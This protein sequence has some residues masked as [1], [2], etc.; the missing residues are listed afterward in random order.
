V[1]L[2]DKRVP[3]IITIASGKG[4]V[5]KTNISV[6][7]ALCLSAEERKVCLLDA[8]IGLA[9]VDI[10]L[11]LSPEHSLLDFLEDRCPLEDTIIKGPGS[12][13]IISGGSGLE[14][15]PYLGTKETSRLKQIFQRI[16][17][18]DALVIDA[19]AGIS[20]QVLRFLDVAGIPILVIV[21]EPTSLTD[22]YS[23][24]KIYNQ[25]GSR[26]PVFVLVN[27]VKSPIHGAKVFSKFSEVVKR[28]LSVSIYSIGYVMS[29]ANLAEAVSKRGPLIELFPD[30]PASVCL[31][32]IA[33]TLMSNT[34][35]LTRPRGLEMLFD[36]KGADKLQGL[37][38]RD[39]AT[40][41][42]GGSDE[43]S[44]RPSPNSQAAEDIIGLFIEEGQISAEQV[45]YAKRVQKML[46][47]PQ[48]LL[49]VLKDLGYIRQEQINESL[50]A[51]RGRLHLGHILVALGH[52]TEDQLRTALTE[53]QRHKKT[54]SDILVKNNIISADELTQVLSS[55]LGIP[56]VEPE[57]EMLDFPRLQKASQHFFRS[58]RLL[59]IGEEDGRVKVVFADP[60]DRSSVEAAE[61]LFGPNISTAVTLPKLIDETLDAY[62]HSRNGEARSD[63]NRSEAALIVDGLIRD[64]LERHASGIHI[65][66]LQN[67]VR[68]RMR[69]DGALTHHMDLPKDLESG[70]VKRIKEMASADMG[71]KPRH[72]VGHICIASGEGG[73]SGEI[74]TSFYVTL[75]GEKVV[76]HLPRKRE[77]NYALED[78]GMSSEILK[79]FRED[80][81]EVPGGLII[82]AGPAGAGKTTTLYAAVSYCNKPD[83][84]IIT[85]E[86]PVEHVVDGVSQCSI[87]PQYGLTSEETFKYM[88]HQ[89][90]DIIILG[91]I[92]NGLAA[93]NA[94]RA[95]LAGRKLI[96]TFN[97]EDAHR[98]LLRLMHMDLAASLVSS[99]VTCVLAQRLLRRVCPNCKKT[100]EPTVTEL[101]RLRYQQDEIKGHNFQM[102]SGCAD[103]HETGYAGRIGVFEM[104]ILDEPL[105]EAILGQKT[106]DAM[107]HISI[108]TA[109]Y[110]TLL[111]D[112]L[113]K[114]AR[115]ITSIQEIL[116]HIPI[117]EAPRP[118]IQ[119]MGSM[120]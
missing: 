80:V 84:N 52:I 87:D 32:R 8:D 111:E 26:G 76:L 7:L 67:R 114:A 74:R 79:R 55:D 86:E 53:R 78:L 45:E 94:V 48:A 9:N 43:R 118:L 113:A 68:I 66:P 36:G 117:M 97:A 28:F 29:D 41:Q 22:A 49:E 110:H 6:N 30:S 103:C 115:G 59:P 16:E 39:E 56:Y 106:C 95:A 100:Y 5:G 61:H 17:G 10:L 75:S 89:D 3:S 35:R 93:K 72:Q 63:E 60:L 90:P 105:R 69:K 101:A 77:K 54:L 31:R 14:R 83:T 4:G 20:D 102:G 12:L 85:A 51:H 88:L 92:K 40:S 57:V 13:E 71:E 1:K 64:A 19:P 33:T 21:P 58:H 70:I 65:E 38:D 15:I 27:Q 2:V 34:N 18:Y 99:T 42:Q 109:H 50:S 25:R 107:R 96:T 62:N 116:K 119:I 47:T 37:S 120:D 91:E 24:L 23:L 112:G 44:D 73:D 108:E 46:D 98:C 82:I 104:L 81:L 11:D